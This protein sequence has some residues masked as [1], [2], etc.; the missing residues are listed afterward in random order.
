MDASPSFVGL[1]MADSWEDEEDDWE[2]D[3]IADKLKLDAGKDEEVWSDEEGHDAHKHV[4][5]AP[6]AAPKPQPP[7]QKSELEKK[8]EAREKRE[9][10]EAEQKAAMRK[11]MGQE[12]LDT[13]NLD[14]ATAEKLRAWVSAW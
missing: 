13:A 1:A 8:I 3:D 7:K 9:K 6:V 5:P 2:K 14:D 12:A 11:Q 4:E 10:E